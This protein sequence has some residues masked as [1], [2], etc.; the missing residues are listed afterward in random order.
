MNKITTIALACLLLASTN[1]LAVS[2]ITLST[3]G[4]T[5]EADQLTYTPA[6]STLSGLENPGGV[7]Y[8]TSFSPVNLTTLD[9]YSGP[10]TLR[11]NLTGLA[12]APTSGGFTITL[13]GGVG[14]YVSTTFNWNSF[15]ASSSTVTVAVN[16]NSIPGG[17]QWN[18]IVGWTWDSGG[19]GNSMNATF[20]QLTATAVPEPSTYAL[21][22]MSA[23]GLGGDVVR[24]R[25]SS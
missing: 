5:V 24:R 11:L 13:E 15:T 22:A 21:L 17:F 2:S 20:T 23:L 16:T 14:N 1:L 19:S 25:R 4:S 12:T 6:T 10:S 8:P 9:N 3:F 18:N 7:L